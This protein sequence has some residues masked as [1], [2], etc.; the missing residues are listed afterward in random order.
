MDQVLHQTHHHPVHRAQGESGQQGGQLRDVHL[1][2]RGHEGHREVQEHEHESD[3]REHGGDG[4]GPDP[5]PA[6]GVGADGGGIGIG[7][8]KHSFL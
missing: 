8:K 2:E 4:H 7:H 6:L 1:D 5:R 3:G